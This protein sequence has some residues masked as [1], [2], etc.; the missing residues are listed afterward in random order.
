M[1][2]VPVDV[3]ESEISLTEFVQSVVAAVPRIDYCILAAG[4][5]SFLL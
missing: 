4:V 5:A 2:V 3:T 1:H